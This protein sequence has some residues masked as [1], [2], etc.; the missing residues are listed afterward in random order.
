MKQVKNTEGVKEDETKGKESFHVH[1]IHLMLA[2]CKC[3]IHYEECAAAYS[4]WYFF[5]NRF[6]DV[7]TSQGRIG[8]AGR[9]LSKDPRVRQ[10]DEEK[11]YHHVVYV[12]NNFISLPP[13]LTFTN[14]KIWMKKTV[15][16]DKNEDGI[17]ERHHVSSNYCIIIIITFNVATYFSH[18]RIPHV[19]LIIMHNKDI[20]NPNQFRYV[21]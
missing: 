5:I 17:E 15:A 16:S 11:S 7:N 2:A 19:M 6:V 4:D 9:I 21:P 8:D 20:E 18:V 14:K 1:Y 13:F 12:P 10:D 3:F